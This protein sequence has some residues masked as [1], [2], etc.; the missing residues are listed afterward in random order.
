MS[1]KIFVVFLYI[2]LFVSCDNR[3]L[4]EF[5]NVNGEWS[6][7]DTLTFCF[8]E[9]NNVSSDYTLRVE[10]RNVHDC[11]YKNI[12]LRVEACSNNY[13][14]SL[15]DTVSC[16]IFSDKGVHNGATAG[17]MYQQASEKIHIPTLNGDTLH[18]KINHIMT[19][20]TIIGVS[21]VGVRLQRLGRHRFSKN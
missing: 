21:D 11:I 15:V 14:K 8:F 18:V 19:E 4:Y 12:L 20:D 5:K 6:R 3:L 2:L 10:L 9:N 13:T 16:E 1:N 17:I 7:G